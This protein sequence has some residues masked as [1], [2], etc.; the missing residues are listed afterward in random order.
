MG[1]MRFAY[2]II[3]GKKTEG[4]KPLGTHKHRRDDNIK[5]N[6]EEMCQRCGQDSVYSG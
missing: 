4:N 3:V 6:H 2:K 1:A 5:T